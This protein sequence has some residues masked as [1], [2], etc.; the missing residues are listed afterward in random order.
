MVVVFENLIHAGLGLLLVERLALGVHPHHHGQHVQEDHGQAEAAAGAGLGDGL[1]AQAGGVGGAVPQIPVD[2]AG[3]AGALQAF[4][5]TGDAVVFGVGQ[6]IEGLG[7]EIAALA[8]GLAVFGDGEVHSVPGLAVDA[9]LLHEVQAALAGVQPFLLHAVH[10]AQV[11]EDPAAAA[12][13]PHALVGGVDLAGAVQAGVDAAVDGIH[14]VFQPEIDAGFQ[15]LFGPG[16][17]LTQ[18]FFVHIAPPCG[19]FYADLYQNQ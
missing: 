6:G 4:P 2:S 19:K 14:A 15:L 8:Q 13:H 1:G 3:L 5:F 12:L 10:V 16:L 9:V 7:V 18:L 11:G 17:G